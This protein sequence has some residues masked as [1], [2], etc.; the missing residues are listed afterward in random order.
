MPQ[1]PAVSVIIAA[2]N[3]ERYILRCLDSLK[4]QTF[5]DFEVIIVNDGS[6]DSTSVIIDSY[7]KKD[8]RFKPIHKPN[9]G[10]ASARQMGLNAATGEYTIHVDADDWVEP[11]MLEEMCNYAFSRGADMLI[12]DMLIYYSDGRIEC[13][14]QQPDSL[15]HLSVLGQMLGELSGSL[16]NKLIRRSC[17]IDCGVR[18]RADLLVCEDQMVVLSL[19]AYPIK[20]FYLGKAYYNYDRRQ[21]K[22]SL[23]NRGITSAESL[24]PLEIIA[25]LVDITPLQSKFDN[26]VF[27]LAYEALFLSNE[28]VSIVSDVFGKYFSS[29]KGADFPWYSKLL[30][31]SAVMRFRTPVY[32]VRLIKKIK[33]K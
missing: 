9:G 29:L 24:K 14:K 23:V 25:G 10:V 32:L 21:N 13:W 16:S 4:A 27:R 3:A 11:E 19:L 20:V 5:K 28:D 12:C 15:E 8:S 26:A 33:R 31:L 22:S 6:T 1:A 18:F 2:Y 7:A 17:Y 30:V